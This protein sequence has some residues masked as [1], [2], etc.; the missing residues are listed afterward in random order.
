MTKKSIPNQVKAEIATV[1]ERFNQEVCQQYMT[2]YVP[3]K[4]LS[5]LEVRTNSREEFQC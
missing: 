1:I 5:M 2:T 3:R 4:L